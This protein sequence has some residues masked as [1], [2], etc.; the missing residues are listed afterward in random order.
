MQ[1]EKA[2]LGTLLKHPHLIGDTR[3]VPDH[4]E[5]SEHKQLLTNMRDLR[6]QNKGVD[7]ITL[8][9][10]YDPNTVGGANYLSELQKMA[11]ELRFDHYET[12]V[13]DHWREREKKGILHRANEE[14]WTIDAITSELDKLHDDQVDDHSDIMGLTVEVYE[15]PYQP[16]EVTPSAPTG[17]SDLDAMNVLNNAELTILAARP[18]MGKS[19]VMLQF[20]KFSGWANY[21]PVIYSLEMARNSLRDRLIASTGGFNRSKMNNPHAKL[22]DGQKAEWIPT[23][24]KLGDTKIQI[25]DKSGQTLAEIRMKLRKVASEHPTRKPIVFIDYLTLIRSVEKT[26]NMHQKIGTLTKGLKALAKEF[27]CP[28]VVLAQLS[29]SVEQ[30]QD[31]RPML[32]DLRESGSIEEDADVVLFLYRDA[33]YSKNQDD[34]SLEISVAKNRN[35]ATGTVF[36]T[37]NSYT[38]LVTNA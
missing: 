15:A 34:K 16:R 5:F 23:L 11:N 29:R 12:A 20:S 2:V 37:Y 18:S 7:V 8:L 27:N 33:Y 9:T 19:D 26:D 14:N 4:F 31:K 38:G 21:L 35:G 6:Q 17:I 24:H 22:T 36:A 13:L 10:Y 28:V 25:F 30:R 32:S 1:A 3:L